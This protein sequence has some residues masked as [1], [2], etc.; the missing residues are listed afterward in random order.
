M[1]EEEVLGKAYDARLMRR[2][3]HYLRPY[4]ANVAIAFVAITAGSAAS[5]A[6][7]YLMKVAIDRYI[8]AG[9]V[10][11]LDRLAILYLVILVV[12]FA[13]EYVQT[14]TMQL[15]GQRVMF[16][17]RMSIYGHLQRLDLKY[18]DRNPV[19]RLMTRV[20]SDV[21]AL[22]D[23]FTAGVITIFGDVFALAGIMIIMIGMNWRLALVAFSVL[24]L[25][26]LVTQWFRRSVRESYRVVRGLI[27][28]INAFLQENITGMA[29]VQLFRREPLN[30]AKFDHID[31]THRDANISSI[32]YYAVFYPAIEAIS[33]LASA[34]I[35]WYGGG[36]VMQSALTLG[37]LV[38]FLQY[39]QRFFR[40][41]SD[42]SDKFNVLQSAMASSE[43]IF[44]LLDEPL[45]VKTP[46]RPVKRQKPVGHIIF[47]R[48]WFAYT[49]EEYVLQDVSFE[50]RPGQRVGIVGATGSGKTTLINLLLRFYDVRRGRI[51]VDGVDIR[52]LDLAELRGLFSL[53][54]QDVHLF[55]GTIADNIRLGHS[56]IDDQRLK[57]AASAVHAEPFIL[58]LPE[59]YQSAVAE[60]GSTLSVGQKQLLSFARALAFDPRVLILDEATSSV[61][62]ET[63]LIIRDALHVLMAGRTTIAIAHR[64]ST[65]QDMDKI[66]VLHKGKLRE[67]GTH[68]ELLAHRGIYFKLFELQ[69]KSERQQEPLELR[70]QN[71]A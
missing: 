56:S 1:H 67:S 42:M 66:L 25:I 52:E 14:W 13:A 11:D 8:A 68:Q 41:I 30:F 54:L 64:L 61:D 59:G 35:I 12:A 23:L 31:A 28:R 5:L 20:T 27:A 48:V 53:V 6:Q 58:R 45:E 21:D 71:S 49:D 17:L 57:R 69:Y 9:R 33:S 44:K 43:R 16:D 34:L 19:G 62:T 26:V 37:A 70:T 22:N 32:F 60:R 65:I 55:S 2:L 15:T 63:E 3:L 29:T 51:L 4:S 50:V 18:Y 36:R 40:P 47:D 10:D 7:P 46:E 24:P 38:A 39:S